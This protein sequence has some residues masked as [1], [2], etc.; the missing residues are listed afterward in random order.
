MILIIGGGIA[1]LQ[2]AIEISNYGLEAAIIEKNPYLGGN[3]NFLHKYFPS[4][5][6]DCS[7]CI[8]SCID[9]PG[10]RKCFYRSSVFSLENLKIYTNSEIKDI[11]RENGVFK[12]IIEKKPRYVDESKC[13]NCELCKEVCPI[14]VDDEVLG[15]RKAI[16]SYPQPVPPVYT[17]DIEACNKCG[18]C[19]EVCKTNAIDFDQKPETIELDAEA[20]IV[21]TGFSEFKPYGIVEYGYGVYKNVITQLELAKMLKQNNFKADRVL[22]IQ[23]VGSRDKRFYGYCSKICCMFAIK[24]AIMLKEE[25]PDIEVYIAYMDIRTPGFYEA[26]YRKARELGVKFIRARPGDIIENDGKLEVYFENTLEKRVEKLEVDYV[27]LS[28]ALIP[29]ENSRRIAEILGLETDEYGFILSKDGKTNVPNVFV[30]G[31]ASSVKDVPETVLEAV[32]STVEV[33]K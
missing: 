11:K 25:N 29:D 5:P 30:A 31:I 17:I 2:S 12:V 26:W 4:M 6:L 27:V 21:A 16:Y 22:M 18:K 1:G 7:V 23:C 9:M 10:I 3:A 24:H 33:I 20:I 15:K 13:V 14:E 19:K 32:A 28:S 8:T